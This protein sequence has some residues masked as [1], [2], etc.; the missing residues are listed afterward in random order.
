METN[1]WETV[2]GDKPPQNIIRDLKPGSTL[3]KTLKEGFNRTRMDIDIIS[4][5]E[6]EETSTVRRTETAKVARDGPPVL[7]VKQYSACLNDPRE[8]CIPVNANHSMVAKLSGSDGSPYHSIKDKVSLMVEKAR[9]VV[10]CRFKR[11]YFIDALKNIHTALEHVLSRLPDT[12]VLILAEMKELDSVS[13][14]IAEAD[15]D[16][17][18]TPNSI[19]LAKISQSI[20]NMKHLFCGVQDSSIAV[21]ADLWVSFDVELQTS[22]A[23]VT[24]HMQDFAKQVI[25]FILDLKEAVEWPNMSSTPGVLEKFMGSTAAKCLGL[26]FVTRRQLELHAFSSE[27]LAP[28]EGVYKELETSTKEIRIGTYHSGKGAERKEVVLEYKPYERD[29]E[30]LSN[31]SQVPANLYKAA[32][33]LATQMKN[34][35]SDSDPTTSIKKILQPAMSIFQ[36]IAWIHD[37]DRKRFVFIYNIPKPFR[38]C[39]HNILGD[40]RTVKSWIHDIRLGQIALDD[41]FYTAYRICQ[42]VFQLHICGWVHKNIN[43]SNIVLIPSPDPHIMK[44]DPALP[45]RHFAT[46]L[47]GFQ[48]SR[49]KDASSRYLP[50]EDKENNIYRHPNRQG[51]PEE[52]AR[53]RQIHDLYAV[54][55]VLLEIGRRKQLNQLI[56]QRKG[57]HPEEIKIQLIEVAKTDVLIFVGHKYAKCVMICLNGDFGIEDDE[58]DEDGMLLAFA[59]RRLVVDELKRMAFACGNHLSS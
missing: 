42:T 15:D 20:E 34:L 19:N 44:A 39:I 7:Y 47:K 49:K 14:I 12:D 2:W 5:F 35:T 33:Q 45:Q 51:L 38:S 30:F 36:C 11:E 28:S 24:R 52:N 10:D 58:A 41:L 55:T 4:C 56:S 37:K 50:A 57:M 32:Q 25:P 27:L 23:A 43:P 6:L 40:I 17:S 46:Y 9:V 53:F 48:F 8:V 54:G 21:S 22:T 26:D 59:F 1:H 29:E 3:L 18:K 31:R 13:R 16:F